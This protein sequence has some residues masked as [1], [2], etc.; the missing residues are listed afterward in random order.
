MHNGVGV[1]KT[2]LV[3]EVKTVTAKKMLLGAR[4]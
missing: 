4:A 3:S 2:M 1:D